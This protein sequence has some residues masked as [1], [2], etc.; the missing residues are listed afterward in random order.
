LSWSINCCGKRQTPACRCRDFHKA[1]YEAIQHDLQAVNWSTILEHLSFTP[2][3]DVFQQCLNVV[4]DKHVSFQRP[5]TAVRKPIWMTHKAYKAV[6]KKYKSFAKYKSNSHPACIRDSARAK[7][8]IKHARHNFES[9]LATNIKS[10]KK[11]FY[12]HVNCKCKSNHSLGPLVNPSG[13]VVNTAPELADEFNR[14][15]ASV[16]IQEDNLIPPLEPILLPLNLRISLMWPS[17][18]RSYTTCLPNC[19]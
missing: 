14:Y 9:K 10:D 18:I 12:A 16:F 13:Q 19:H 15:F 1:D 3:W 5:S 8:A 4:I 6:Q 11:L 2:A 7:K 17:N